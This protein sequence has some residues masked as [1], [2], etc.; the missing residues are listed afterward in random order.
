MFSRE[1]YVREVPPIGPGKPLSGHAQQPQWAVVWGLGSVLLLAALIALTGC[2]LLDGARL[3]SIFPAAASPP[4]TISPTVSLEPGTTLAATPTIPS[5]TPVGVPAVTRTP[6]VDANAPLTLT[7]WL[8]PEMAISAQTSGQVINQLNAAFIA[9][10]RQVHIEVLS[11]AA[12][13]AG[14]VVNMLLATRPVVPARM[15]DIIVLDVAELYRLANEDILYPLDDLFPQ[16]L[17]DD[18]FPFS[19]DAVTVNGKKLAM[20]FQTDISFLVYNTDAIQAP[21]RTWKEMEKAS[22]HYIFPAGEGDGSAADAFLLHYLAQGGELTQRDN[23][24]FLDSAVVAKVLRNYHTA[25]ESG[26]VPDSVRTLRTLDDCWAAFLTG[27]AGMANTSSWHYQRDH[28]ALPSAHYAQIPTDK[29]DPITLAHAWSWAIV[30]KDPQR[31]EVAVRYIVS[32]LRPEFLSA[33][34][35]ASFHL[36]V[37]RSVLVRMIS[38][39]A[40]QSFL[41]EQLEHARPYPDVQGYPEVQ[42]ALT[43]AIEDVLDGVA[44][45]ERAAVSAAAMVA[46]LR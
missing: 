16:G 8:P 26:A 19:L 34:S 25:I 15:P 32:A 23:Q 13:G 21:P 20:P 33:W 40:Y 1:K 3:G 39:E 18:L 37:H 35:A 46:R 38:D 22:V 11:K 10:N 45:P 17:W 36:P 14:G 7:L 12:Y 2:S 44:T 27:D 6:V 28:A 5:A 42:G 41:V 29:G 9:S 30:T 4:A 24:P 31:Q 43:R